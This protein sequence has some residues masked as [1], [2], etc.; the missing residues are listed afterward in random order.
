MKYYPYRFKTEKE[1]IDSF[2]IYWRNVF[3]DIGWTSD[4][5]YL[6]GTDFPKEDLV[7]INDYKPVLSLYRDYIYGHSIFIACD[8]NWVII[9]KMLTKNK[10]KEPSYKPRKIT[11]EL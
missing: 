9:P 7:V 3:A 11:R 8:F 4:M 5:N 10:P 1:M 2:G 6:L